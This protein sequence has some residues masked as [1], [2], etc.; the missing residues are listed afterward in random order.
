[1]A[2]SASQCPALTVTLTTSTC[3]LNFAISAE[4]SLS[5]LSVI[6]YNSHVGNSYLNAYHPFRCDFGQLPIQYNADHSIKLYLFLR[7]GNHFALT[8]NI[9]CII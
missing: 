9:I 3:Y 5:V 7:L 6:G 1:M 4:I 2:N 8:Y